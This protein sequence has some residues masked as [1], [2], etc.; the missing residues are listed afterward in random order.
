MPSKSTKTVMILVAIFTIGAA[1]FPEFSGRLLANDSTSIKNQKPSLI[2]TVSI[3]GMTCQGCANSIEKSLSKV[4]IVQKAVVSY[5]NR[6]ATVEL[7]IPDRE[8]SE[9]LIKEKINSFGYKVTKID[10][11]KP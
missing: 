5:E 3:S 7:K 1:F 2:A 6:Q 11:S 8:K 9:K 10:W 4:D